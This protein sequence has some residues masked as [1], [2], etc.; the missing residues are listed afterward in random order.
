MGTRSELVTL[1]SFMDVTG[2]RPVIDRV[3]PLADAR[4]GFE[5]MIGGEVFGKVVFTV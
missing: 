4:A 5:A 1:L 3:L 2:V